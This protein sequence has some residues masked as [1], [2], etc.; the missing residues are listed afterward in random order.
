MLLKPEVCG[1]LSNCRPHLKAATLLPAVSLRKKGGVLEGFRICRIL[2][3]VDSGSA[4]KSENRRPDPGFTL[5]RPAVL[6]QKIGLCSEVSDFSPHF[7]KTTATMAF[8][9][10]ESSTVSAWPIHF[11]RAHRNLP[12][13]PQEG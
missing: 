7:R 5:P 10:P 3:S 8:I 1:K 4:G 11:E 6:F 12:P 9:P 2:P 13:A